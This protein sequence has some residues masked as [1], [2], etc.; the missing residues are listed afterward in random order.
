MPPKDELL[1]TEEEIAAFIDEVTLKRNKPLQRTIFQPND[2]LVYIHVGSDTD[3]DRQREVFTVH[4]NLL[5]ARSDYFKAAF[6]GTFTEA[7]E[8]RITLE[9]ED[10]D[11]FRRFWSWLYTGNFYQELETFVLWCWA[12]DLYIF[13]EKRFIPD[14]QNAVMDA[15]LD[16]SRNWIGWMSPE[17]EIPR[18]WSKVSEGSPLRAYLV[19]CFLEV[20][21]LDREFDGNTVDLYPV[22]FLVAI[23]VRAQQLKRQPPKDERELAESRCQRYHANHPSTNQP[24]Q[25]MTQPVFE[26]DAE[27]STY[28]WA[29]YREGRGITS[30]VTDEV[31]AMN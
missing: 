29:N 1:V 9:D 10:P 6:T 20:G 14:L 26:F 22:N 5:C 19:D 2:S 18:V 16:S 30:D 13:A 17:M 23:V 31:D 21:E 25:K 15:M 8:G 11:T 3:S 27:F 24:C 12:L 28:V 7:R 4:K